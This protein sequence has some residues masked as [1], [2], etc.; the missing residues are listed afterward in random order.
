MARCR[1]SELIRSLNAAMRLAFHP[2]GCALDPSRPC[3]AH[4]PFDH[5]VS[6]YGHD[7][8]LVALWVINAVALWPEPLYIVR[9]LPVTKGQNGNTH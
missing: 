1:D 2:D 3:L 7:P 8:L 5:D 9:F 4:L 6:V